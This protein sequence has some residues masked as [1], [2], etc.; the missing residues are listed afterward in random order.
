MLDL[1][2]WREWRSRIPASCPGCE[3][4]VAGQGL[5]PDCLVELL[6]THDGARCPRC[7]H[8]LGQSGCPDCGQRTLAFDRVVAAF[9]YRGLGRRLLRD[10]KLAGHLQLAS[11]LSDR[12]IAALREAAPPDG[13][14]V[15]WVV[16]VPAHQ[17]SLRRRGYSPPAEVGRIV[18]RRLRLRYR[19]D[20][21]RRVRDG[22]R[23]STL[24]R[25]ARLAAPETAF[26]CERRLDRVAAAPGWRVA[27][28][29]DVLTTGA[30]LHAAASV[31]KSAGAAHVE[32]WVLARSL[33]D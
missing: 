15:D 10:Y 20:L 5:C 17:D 7:A 23:Q 22:P 25:T 29:D 18:A 13:P 4:R 8:P 1:R 2:P 14:Q 3:R 21:L 6:P 12:L 31:L 26:A 24:G 19:L 32:G 28:V 27:V 9:D 16:P 11:L 33:R 30:T